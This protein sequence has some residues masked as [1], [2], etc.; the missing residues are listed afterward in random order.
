MQ[1]L[2]RSLRVL[3]LLTGEARG[4]PMG[5]IAARLDMPVPSTHRILAV[6]E[7][8]RFVTRSPSNRRYFLG[9]V[10]RELSGNDLARESPLV[11]PHPAVAAASRSSG[12]TVFLAELVGT[13]VVCLALAQSEHPLRLF[14]RVGQEMPLHAAASAR[15]LLAGRSSAEAR[16]LLAGRIPLTP[17]TS[18]TP[19]DIDQV[20]SR[21]ALVTA[22]GYDIC[23]AELE[24]N[25]WS[26]SAP[27]RS[28]TDEVVASVT[29][30]APRHR[31]ADQDTR[32][33]ALRTVL[34]AAAEMSAD[35]GWSGA[36]APAA[37]LAPSE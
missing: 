3:R 18:D 1:V 37:R 30:A 7:S 5:E 12:E 33:E 36:P 8:E 31:V 35:L 32:D 14:V 6:L 25:V 4:L 15:V 9:P 29:L 27:I 11:T 17:F 19:A 13:R 16:A 24:L 28:S 10:A 20:I 23:D 26:V 2:I 21:L 34:S 22:R